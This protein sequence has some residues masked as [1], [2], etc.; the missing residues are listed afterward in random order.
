MCSGLFARRAIDFDDSLLVELRD[1][2]G[3][4]ATRFREPGLVILG[5]AI[6]EYGALKLT[7]SLPDQSGG[8]LL[9]PPALAGQHVS[10]DG[11]PS[12]FPTAFRLSFNLTI[13]TG[14][15]LE[16]PVEARQGGEGVAVSIGELPNLPSGE[17]GD[18]ESLRVS[19][20][21]RANVLRI[22]YA[23]RELHS[24]RLPQLERL[25]SNASFPVVITLRN[26]SLSVEVADTAV[27]VDA[28]LPEVRLYATPSWRFGLSARTNHVRGEN[29]FVDGLRLERG[30]SLDPTAVAVSVT[31]N[32][33]QYAPLG[34]PSSI[35]YFGQPEPFSVEPSLGPVHGGTRLVIRGD[36]LHG[37]A[38]I[39]ANHHRRPSP[40]RVRWPAHPNASPERPL[41]AAASPAM[42]EIFLL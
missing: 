35:I 16:G 33:Q 18:G 28:P 22:A 21:T 10:L 13:G 11:A 20:R 42:V 3:N 9:T 2:A 14:Y 41:L 8:F 36:E 31:S 34:E 4:R 6:I 17:F 32:G 7:R 40:S 29:H 5:D 26:D 1:L 30:P 39:I 23:D 27:L 12:T 24:G 37:G 25:R 38:L 15:L 19:M